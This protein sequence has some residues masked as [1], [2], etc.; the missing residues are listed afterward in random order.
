M[1]VVVVVGTVTSQSVRPVQERTPWNSLDGRL[2]SS[3]QTGLGA[4]GLSLEQEVHGF[5]FSC[6]C[7]SSAPWGDPGVPQS[8]SSIGPGD[9]ASRKPPRLSCL[10]PLLLARLVLEVFLPG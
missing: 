8:L 2:S 10:C 7:P 5:C 6:I 3:R 1:V 9:T 4:Q